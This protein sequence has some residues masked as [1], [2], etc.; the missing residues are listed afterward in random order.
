MEDMECHICSV[1]TVF[2]CTRCGE[3]VCDSCCVPFT[4]QNQVDYDLCTRCG[5]NQEDE[6]AEEMRREEE[7]EREISRKLAEHN[8]KVAHMNNQR[9]KFERI[10]I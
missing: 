1:H 5:R 10:G 7:R 4:L 9:R 2:F 6:Y 8:R 3:P